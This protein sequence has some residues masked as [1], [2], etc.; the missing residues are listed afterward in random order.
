MAGLSKNIHWLVIGL[1][2]VIVYTLLPSLTARYFPQV[3]NYVV[4]TYSAVGEA[5]YTPDSTST[6]PKEEARAKA[7]ESAKRNAEQVAALANK[8]LGRLTYIS[9]NPDDT[10]I[11]ADFTEGLEK[12][13]TNSADTKEKTFTVTLTFELY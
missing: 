1:I 11:A 10:Y 3:S 7:F 13:A 9:E 5:K 8:R 6:K 12:P 2:L 4:P